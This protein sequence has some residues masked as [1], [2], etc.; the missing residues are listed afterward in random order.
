[1]WAMGILVDMNSIKHV[2]LTK[3]CCIVGIYYFVL[4][5]VAQLTCM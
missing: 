1:M 3:T 2:Y 4:F 5:I